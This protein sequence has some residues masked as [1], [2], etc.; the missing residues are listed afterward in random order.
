MLSPFYIAVATGSLDCVRI[1][2]E[3]LINVEI[4]KGIEI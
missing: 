2:A 3:E 4:D 1:L